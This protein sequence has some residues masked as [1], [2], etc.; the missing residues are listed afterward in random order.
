MYCMGPSPHS[1]VCDCRSI[2][3]TNL[4]MVFDNARDVESNRR[5]DKANPGVVRRTSASWLASHASAVCQTLLIMMNTP[6]LAKRIRISGQVH[7]RTR[8]NTV[9]GKQ[10]VANRR[11][12]RA[13]LGLLGSSGKGLKGCACGQRLPVEQR[14]ALFFTFKFEPQLPQARHRGATGC[15]NS[16][17]V[18][19]RDIARARIKPGHA[20]SNDQN[21]EQVLCCWV[22]MIIPYWYDQNSVL[23]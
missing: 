11:A 5:D 19:L 16:R 23:A 12:S 3:A 4:T 14:Q 21:S 18:S 10:Q 9:T 17:R 6:D 15:S 2:L 8:S 1:N 7:D 22:V 20:I 13:P